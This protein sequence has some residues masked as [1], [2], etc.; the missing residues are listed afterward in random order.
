MKGSP[1][2]FCWLTVMTESLFWMSQC[3]RSQHMSYVL[4]LVGRETAFSILQWYRKLLTEKRPQQ[5]Q[6]KTSAI[7]ATA[8]PPYPHVMASFRSQK[9]RTETQSHQI[10]RKGGYS[11]CIYVLSDGSLPSF[12]NCLWWLI[13]YLK[14]SGLGGLNYSKLAICTNR[15]Y[16]LIIWNNP[17]T[18][19][20][21]VHQVGDW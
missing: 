5:R 7:S 11:P 10:L 8:M 4:Q 13:H 16:Q 21:K 19:N 18:L 2:T 1:T 15:Q 6:P 3:R 17:T 12:Y 14:R 9:W 20:H